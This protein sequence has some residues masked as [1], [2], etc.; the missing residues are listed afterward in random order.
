MANGDHYLKKVVK[1]DHDY[2]QSC[3]GIF[4]ISRAS[5]RLALQSFISMDGIPGDWRYA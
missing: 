5:S 1:I 3:A 2:G 4:E